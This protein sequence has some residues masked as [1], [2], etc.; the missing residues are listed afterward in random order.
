MFG[1]FLGAKKDFAR[2]TIYMDVIANIIPVVSLI[3][4]AYISPNVVSLITTYFLSNCA[5]YLYLYFRTKDIYRVD[6]TKRDSHMLIYG[7]HLSLI[8][9]LA[10]FAGNID[11][12][13]LFH[14]V[15]A[16]QLAVYV[17]ATGILDQLKGPLKT[18]DTMMQARF[19]TR[20]DKDLQS[21]MPSKMLWMFLFSTILIVGFIIFVPYVYRILFPKYIEAIPYAQVY[22]FLLLGWTFTPVTSYL[23]SKKRIREQYFITITASVFQIFAVFVGIVGWGLWG[24]IIARVASSLTTGLI[25]ILVYLIFV[26]NR[27][28]VLR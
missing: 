6:D 10:G 5:V 16:A 23:V 20:Q 1:P 8:G 25:T 3:V 14:Y 13:L 26:R 15:A 4:T 28:E 7:K 19:A 24:L 11:K 21:G 27:I 17:F 18:L 22:A 9:V 2:Q 12:L